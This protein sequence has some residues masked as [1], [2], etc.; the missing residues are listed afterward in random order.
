MASPT[1]ANPAQARSGYIEVDRIQDPDGALAVLSMRVG[2]PPICSIA[3]FKTFDRDGAEEKTAFF[4]HKMID[5]VK[6]VVDIAGPRAQELER[7]YK[8]DYEKTATARRER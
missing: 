3:I 2:G 4:S 8:A 5:S 7:R 6:R 1:P